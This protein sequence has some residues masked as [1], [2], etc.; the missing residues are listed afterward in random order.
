MLRVASL[1]RQSCVPRL[2]PTAV[3]LSPP[4]AAPGRL[5]LSSTAT[6]K[7]VGVDV[8][9]F[10]DIRASDFVYVD[11]TAHLFA[12]AEKC[13][14]KF[15]L[16]PRKFGKTLALTT[17]A[18]MFDTDVE[19]KCALFDGTW[20]A[21]HQ[22]EWLAAP[23]QQATVLHFDFGRVKAGDFEASLLNQLRE[24]SDAHGI[25]LAN[26]YG[27]DVP[28]TIARMVCAVPNPVVLVDEYDKPIVNVLE[29]NG[30]RANKLAQDNLE[31]MRGLF[32]TLKGSSL[33][34]SFVTGVSKFALSGL[35][36]GTNHYHDISLSES[37]SSMCGYTKQ[38]VRDNF[39]EHAELVRVKNGMASVGEVLERAFKQYNG[40]SWTDTR[41]E[42]TVCNPFS[43]GMLFHKLKFGKWRIRQ[44][45][46][47]WLPRVLK[48]SPAFDTTV[49]CEATMMPKFELKP[50]GQHAVDSA[51]LMLQTGY[52]TVKEYD[53]HKG[54]RL[55]FP[56]EEVRQGFDEIVSDL[57]GM[58]VATAN[59]ILR[60][61]QDALVENDFLKVVALCEESLRAVPHQ[62]L[63]H[64]QENVY[65]EHL[66]M[67]LSFVPNVRVEAEMSDTSGDADLIV[68]TQAAL[69]VIEVKLVG[70]DAT[71][72]AIA[73]ALARGMA[74]AKARFVGRN[75]ESKRVHRAA[76]VVR[77]RRSSDAQ[78]QDALAGDALA[79]NLIVAAQI[80]D[81]TH[82]DFVRVMCDHF[83]Q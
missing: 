71:A 60:E 39:A 58:P 48:A 68:H 8:A 21:Q 53:I 55:D 69:H 19:R 66:R 62:S 14:H 40:Y 16:R 13:G 2:A 20:L 65:R 42:A 1:F 70:A 52:L 10:E 82:E 57:I 24:V 11:K 83:A 61:L 12:L 77:Q 74:Q 36:S 51:N 45:A 35:F 78:Q 9:R 7:P 28:A 37:F 59:I 76:I 64:S 81:S 43:I 31:I 75:L 22:A 23:A 46:S 41:D 56:N 6:L 73:S 80:G 54:M 72:A 30:G 79:H 26:V 18:A 63:R 25:S 33:R 5:H 3:R 67:M 15:L 34:F 29:A 47:G 17:L 49:F 4:A 38:E 32:D 44:G 27:D 50:D